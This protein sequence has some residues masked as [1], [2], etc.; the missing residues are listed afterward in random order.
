MTLFKASTVRRPPVLNKRLISMPV[1]VVTSEDMW[2]ALSRLRL[3]VVTEDGVIRPPTEYRVSE[4]LRAA[5]NR[6]SLAFW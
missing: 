4:S 5:E 6:S 2:P 3:A 1:S